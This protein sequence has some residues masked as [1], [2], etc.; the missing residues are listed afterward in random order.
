MHLICVRHGGTPETNLVSDP[1]RTHTSPDMK[2]ARKLSLRAVDLR[3]C[4]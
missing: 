3:L 1:V 4:R 2:T